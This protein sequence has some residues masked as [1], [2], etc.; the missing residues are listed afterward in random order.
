MDQ[1]WFHH[2]FVHTPHHVDIRIP[3][4]Q[5]PAAAAAIK[6]HYPTPVRS[7]RLSLRSYL[8]TTKTC[9]LYDF[10]NGTWLPYSAAKAP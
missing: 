7:D 3:F 9:K 8:R 6:E 4:H 2:I 10:K 1:L 5:L